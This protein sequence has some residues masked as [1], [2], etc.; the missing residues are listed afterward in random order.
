MQTASNQKI[1]AYFKPLFWS[2]DFS[3]LDPTKDKKTIV[4]QTIN[5]GDLVHWRWLI[6]HY[7]QTEIQTVL[8]SV[9]ATALRE[10]VRQL[11]GA[12]F[13]VTDFNYAPRGS[14]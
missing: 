14:H 6:H 1:P 10:R 9:P 5:Y 13:S 11:A 4:L 3:K 2:Y 7:G 8:K 12:I